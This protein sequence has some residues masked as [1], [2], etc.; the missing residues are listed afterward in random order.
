MLQLLD[1][2]KNYGALEIIRHSNHQ[3]DKG[4]YWLQGSNGSGKSTVLK[5]IAGILWFEGD[6]L[7]DNVSPKRQPT[8]YRKIVKFCPAEQ[9][10]V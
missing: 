2:R 6:I 10:T 5:S 3:V 9:W 8:T 7:F 4:I 1:Y